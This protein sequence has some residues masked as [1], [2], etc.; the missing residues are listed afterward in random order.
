MA[1]M[2]RSVTL[3]LV[4]TVGLLASAVPARAQD[5]AADD[6]VVIEIDDQSVTYNGE[7]V[8]G[9]NALEEVLVED[10]EADP[11][12]TVKVLAHDTVPLEYVT[13]IVEAVRQYEVECEVQWVSSDSGQDDNM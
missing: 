3:G 13:Q 5:D 8:D 9:L 7:A 4:L 11:A 2:L 12:L 10:I 1:G 6:D